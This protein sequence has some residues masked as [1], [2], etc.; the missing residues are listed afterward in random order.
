VTFYLIVVAHTET[1]NL[2]SEIQLSCCLW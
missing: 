2:W 1:Y